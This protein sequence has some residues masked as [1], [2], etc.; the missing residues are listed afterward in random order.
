MKTPLATPNAR[1]TYVAQFPDAVSRP[2]NVAN[3]GTNG[4]AVLTRPATA[5]ARSDTILVRSISFD[6]AGEVLQTVD[7]A[8]MAVRYGYY[9]A[10]RETMVTENYG[11]SSGGGT[12]CTASDDVNRITQRTYTADGQTATR[13]DQNGSTTN[14][15]STYTC[16]TTLAESAIATAMMLRYV[17]YPD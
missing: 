17:D 13:V 8:G 15:P 5:P 12:L 1:V 7:P 9:A 16:G 14:Q 4:G 6:S 3:Y 11:G 2:V 10:G